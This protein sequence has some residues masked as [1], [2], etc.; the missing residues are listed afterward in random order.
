M[1]DEKDLINNSLDIFQDGKF[2]LVTQISYIESQMVVLED[3]NLEQKEKIKGATT[4]IFKGKNE[5]KSL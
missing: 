3:E 5:A 4:I 2:A 1:T